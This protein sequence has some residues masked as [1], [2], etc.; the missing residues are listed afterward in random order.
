LGG[1][2]FD[3]VST[4]KAFIAKR[5]LVAPGGQFLVA[6]HTQRHLV[7][8]DPTYPVKV[9]MILVPPTHGRATP[10]TGYLYDAHGTPLQP[11]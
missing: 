10:P 9:A 2:I 5:D 11:I 6:A 8:I 7:T 3:R 4:R 1:R